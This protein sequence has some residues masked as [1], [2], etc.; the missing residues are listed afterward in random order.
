MAQI[1]SLFCGHVFPSKLAKLN[2]HAGNALFTFLCSPIAGDTGGWYHS[3]CPWTELLAKIVTPLSLLSLVTT[4]RLDPEIFYSLSHARIA[5][6]PRHWVKPALQQDSE[7]FTK[8]P[9]N[10]LPKEF[11]DVVKLTELTYLPN[12]LPEE[13]EIV[14]LS[15]SEIE[16]RV[17][18]YCGLTSEQ[19]HKTL[20]P[21]GS[22]VSGFLKNGDKLGS[23]IKRD[24]E[25]LIALK[26]SRETLARKLCDVIQAE[27]QHFGNY[28]YRDEFSVTAQHTMGFQED[29]FHPS[30][31]NPCAT[32]TD[33]TYVIKKN[34]GDDHLVVA[35]LVPLLIERLCFF[36]TSSYRV[37]PAFAIKFF[38]L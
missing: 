36:E 31:L 33:A 14:K 21:E 4:V 29:P 15:D 9:F 8:A 38:G 27:P 24:A 5:M 35:G 22:S 19:L 26:V 3:T 12:V 23:V 18:E 7:I 10:A 17:C 2:S 11:T 20:Y 13:A 1:N 16:A 34:I 28:N 25:T 37:D 6:L 30:F 32:H